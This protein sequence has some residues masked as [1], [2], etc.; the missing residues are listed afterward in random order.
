MYAY[1]GGNPISLTD[2]TGLDVT[3]CVYR[4]ALGFNHVGVA[5]NSDQTVGYYPTEGGR[6][7]ISGT[8]G[9]VDFDDASKGMAC[10]TIKTDEAADK[11]MQ[12]QISAV[13]SSPG[14]YTLAGNNCADF[15]GGVLRAGGVDGVPTSNRP[16]FFFPSLSG[17]LSFPFNN[18]RG[19][20]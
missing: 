1:V 12:Q 6:S 9:M 10:K 15:V 11:R 16:N 17:E 5:V 20:R 7:A 18:N 4:G 8:L 19:G 13:S 14:T 2:P 3:I